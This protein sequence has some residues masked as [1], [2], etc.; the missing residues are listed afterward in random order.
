MLAAVLGH[1][2]MLALLPPDL[3]EGAPRGKLIDQGSKG[4]VRASNADRL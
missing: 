3:P 4:R 1:G 2:A